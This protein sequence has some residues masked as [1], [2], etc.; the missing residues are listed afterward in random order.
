MHLTEHQIVLLP[1]LVCNGARDDRSA[2]RKLHLAVPTSMRQSIYRRA[3]L[4]DQALTKA[5]RFP[6]FFLT[7]NDDLAAVIADLCIYPIVT[8]EDY[9]FEIIEDRFFVRYQHIIGSRHLATLSAD[10]LSAICIVLAAGL[11]SGVSPRAVVK[12]VTGPLSV[13]DELALLVAEDNR[14]QLPTSHL[15][16][17]AEI[18]KRIT[19]AGGRYNSRGYFEFPVGVVPTEVLD[20]LLAGQVVNGKKDSQSFFSPPHVAEFVCASAGSLTGKRVIE[21][22]AGDGALADIAVREGADVT[23]I[24]NH[25]PNVLSLQGKGYEVIDRDF[26]TVTP[27]EVGLF[28]VVL[29]NPPFSGGQDIAHIKHMW[30]FLKPGGVLSTIASTTWLDGTT[31][32]AMQFR[33]FLAD[34]DAAMSTIDAGAFKS[35]G[36]SVSTVHILVVKQEDQLAKAA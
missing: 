32:K 13:E 16:H 31:A 12:P 11:M 17:Y 35:S 23:V 24:E 27:E 4:D 30:G 25:R 14:L 19:R 36:T 10:T 2:G 18:K 8:A 9:Y 33:Q 7:I 21:P 26:L 3:G 34:N 22:S 29:A 20:G 15:A 28:D 5:G 6:T 1:S